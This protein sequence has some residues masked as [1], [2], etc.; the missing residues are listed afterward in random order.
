MQAFHNDSDNDSDVDGD[1]IPAPY[2]QSIISDDDNHVNTYDFDDIDDTDYNIDSESHIVITDITDNY[3]ASASASNATDSASSAS[4]VHTNTYSTDAIDTTNAIASNVS[5]ISNSLEDSDTINR[6][7]IA[8]YITTQWQV[9]GAKQAEKNASIMQQ[10]QAQSM[11]PAVNQNNANAS[12]AN[13]QQVQ[14][15]SYTNPADS[16]Y[17]ITTATNSESSEPV[18]PMTT[19]NMQSNQQ[20]SYNQAYSQSQQYNYKYDNNQA[21]T[22]YEDNVNIGL[23]GDAYMNAIQ[24]HDSDNDEQSELIV[25]TANKDAGYDWL[26]GGKDKKNRIKRRIRAYLKMSIIIGLT[27]IIILGAIILG[28]SAM[29]DYD[30]FN[31]QQDI[32][33]QIRLEEKG[34]HN[35]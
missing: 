30:G 7:E 6:N 16:Q 2:H 9:L 8:N 18:I 10:M 15:A 34:T 28:K 31:H 29:P 26:N 17:Q 20:Y 19:A 32:E 23:D 14:T 11:Q 5:N 35:D 24:N 3:D 22:F 27:V 13:N 33:S 21:Q 12:N 4:N 1:I 25:D